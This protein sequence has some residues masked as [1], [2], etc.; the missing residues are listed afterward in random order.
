[1]SELFA[2]PAECVC[3]VAR[4]Q[5]I[6]PTQRTLILYDDNDDYGTSSSSTLQVSLGNLRTP[7]NMHSSVIAPGQCVQIYGR[8]IRQAGDIIRVDALF[9]RSL[10]RDFDLNEY[11]KGLL[12][13]R[14]HMASRQDGTSD[15]EGLADNSGNAIRTIL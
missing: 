1:M 11:V 10:A 8:V 2:S 5:S 14:Q 3:I 15:N 7:L 12:L 6:N 4:V 13:T 9:I